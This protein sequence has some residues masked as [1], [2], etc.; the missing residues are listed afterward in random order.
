MYMVYAA[1]ERMTTE[2]QHADK[3]NMKTLS[4]FPTAITLLAK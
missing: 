1:N 3:E 2:I 4:A